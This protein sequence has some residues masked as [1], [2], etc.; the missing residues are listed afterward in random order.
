MK[1]IEIKGV[2][3]SY[4]KE[5]SLV[6]ALQG[7]DLVIDKGEMIAI[8]G[9]SGSG[10]STLLNI[11]G[12]LDKPTEGEYIFEGENTQGFKDS[13]L[14]K[15]RNKHIGFV[16]QNFAL[17][18]D[19]TVYQNIK[20]PLDYMRVPRKKKKQ[21]IDSLLEKM[22]ISDKKDKL[23]KE[24]SGGQNQ[25]VAIARSLANSPDIIMADEPTGALDTKTG[26]DIMNLFLEL[27][28]EGKTVI[29]ITHDQ[30]V[31]NLC[32]RIIRIEDGHVK[33]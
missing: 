24:L 14:A 6:L 1:I 10:K 17:I 21:I 13:R 11:L 23:P 32:K 18:D 19:Y 33:E 15:L 27:N 30:R 31:A 4:G 9:P 2:K 26:E 3:K 29:I 22:G 20:I 28:K 16:V 12:F 7:I 25:R 5:N 8:M